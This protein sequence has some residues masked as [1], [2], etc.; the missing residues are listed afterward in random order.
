MEVVVAVGIAGIMITGIAVAMKNV[1][2][3][4]FEAKREAIINR[5]IYNELTT[6]ATRPRLSEGQ[7]PSRRVEEWDIEIITNITPLTEVLNEDG[8]VLNNLMKIEVS[9]SFWENSEYVTRT[10]ETWRNTRLYAN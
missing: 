3:L 4:S 5:I 8:Q 7:L 10:A 6:V 2:R 9:A 1:T